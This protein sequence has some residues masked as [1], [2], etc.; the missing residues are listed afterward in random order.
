MALTITSKHVPLIV[1]SEEG[2]RL[3]ERRKME[4]LREHEGEGPG[5]A[6][7]AAPVGQAEGPQGPQRSAAPILDTILTNLHTHTLTK[8]DDIPTPCPRFSGSCIGKPCETR[9][10]RCPYALPRH[11]LPRDQKHRKRQRGKAYWLITSAC[12][13]YST[14]AIWWLTLTS[15]PGSR[16]I[17]KSWNALRTRMDRTSRQDIINWLLNEKR[18]GFSKKEQRYC[19]KFYE[20]KDPNVLVEYRYIAIKTNEGN[21]VYHMFIFGDMFPASWLRYWWMKYH[22]DSKMLKIERLKTTSGDRDRLRKYALAQY[23]AG[24][25]Q[26]VRLSHSKDILFPKQVKVYQALKDDHGWKEGLDIWK[27]S[28]KSHLHPHEFMKRW[29][30]AKPIKPEEP[31]TIPESQKMIESAIEGQ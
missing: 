31:A 1:D 29:C 4:A 10:G 2:R 8:G 21:G 14:E 26:F 7:E 9:G 5:R 20:G 18:K 27:G 30:Y 25:D 16:P 15:A 28:M 22:C 12:D 11:P 19:L 17:D 23:A 24:Q 6:P 3:I 13:F